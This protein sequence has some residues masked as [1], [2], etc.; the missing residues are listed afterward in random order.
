MQQSEVRR[1]TGGFVSYQHVFC[2]KEAS[3]DKKS[4]VDLMPIEIII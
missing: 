3:C 2:G 4:V 1:S